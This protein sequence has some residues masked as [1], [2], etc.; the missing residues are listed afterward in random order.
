MT[1]PRRGERLLTRLGRLSRTQV[2]LGA[3]ALAAL[4]LFVPGPVGALVMVVIVA[5]LAWLLS[6][7]WSVTPPALR[8][9][10]LIVLGGLVAFALVKI[11]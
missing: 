4:G 1:G 2:F 6:V 5:A 10:R 8:I 3:L 7:T 9:F 11:L